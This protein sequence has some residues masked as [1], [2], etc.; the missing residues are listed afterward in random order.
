MNAVK[1]LK[2]YGLVFAISGGLSLFS[3]AIGKLI[4]PIIGMLVLG[5]GIPLSAFLLAIYY[6][7]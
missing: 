6:H 7:E 2:F 5:F 3:I 1:R 4:D